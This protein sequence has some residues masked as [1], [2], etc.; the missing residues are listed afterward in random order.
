MKTSVKLVSLA[1][2][3]ALGIGG[4]TRIVSAQ[5]PAV[6]NAMPAA[7]HA[8]HQAPKEASDGDGE[9]NDDAQNQHES[10]SLQALPQATPAQAQRSAEA[11]M[12]KPADPADPAENEND[13]G[14]DGVGETNE[15]G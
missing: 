11:T 10:A 4:L 8:T 15:G 5:P 3:T 6:S 1:L 13:G 7:D 9:T 12:G 2:L 14:N